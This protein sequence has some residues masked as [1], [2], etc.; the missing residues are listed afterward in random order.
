MLQNLYELVLHYEVPFVYQDSES[1]EVHV[2]DAVGAREDGLPKADH[3]EHEELLGVEQGHPAK[4]VVEGIN[5]QV[6]ESLPDVRSDYEKH[7][8]D[9]FEF[10]CNASLRL[11]EVFDVELDYSAHG[12]IQ[13]EKA[14][15]L[16]VLVDWFVPIDQKIKRSEDLVH[17]LNI[18]DARIE[19]RIHKQYS[20]HDMVSISDSLRLF[21]THKLFIF[22]LVLS[23]E[24]SEFL[25]SRSSQKRYHYGFG[26][27]AEEC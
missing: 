20:A 4:T 9:G 22:L 19:F 25:L 6:V 23:I 10:A 5:F 8:V 2:L 12:V 11:V 13:H 15:S 1:D 24:K 17:T 16:L 3:V 27:L 26:L 7:L 18:F 21:A 14:T